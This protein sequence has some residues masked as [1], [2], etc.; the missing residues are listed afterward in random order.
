MA[1]VA[2]TVEEILKEF[3]RACEKFPSWPSD[4]LHALAVLGEEYGE[5][6]KAVLQFMYEP[7]KGVTISDIKEEAIQTAAMALRFALSIDEYN[8]TPREQLQQK[9]S[10]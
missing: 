8:Y 4:P 5:L 1:N 7:N 10:E 3:S 6:D 9:I 2:K